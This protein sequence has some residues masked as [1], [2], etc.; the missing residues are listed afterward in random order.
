MKNLSGLPA[1][2]L[3]R[4]EGEDSGEC[5]HYKSVRSGE[6]L[7]LNTAGAALVA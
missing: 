3:I 2:C 7:P 1:H 4:A 5:S 6:I